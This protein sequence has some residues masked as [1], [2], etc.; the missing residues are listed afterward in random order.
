MRTPPFERESPEREAHLI[1]LA[2]TVR[3]YMRALGAKEQI[4]A[5]I[6]ISDDPRARLGGF[7]E[8]GPSGGAS[9]LG[10]T[11]RFLPG[12]RDT[13]VN[14]GGRQVIVGDGD[15]RDS[16]SSPDDTSAHGGVSRGALSGLGVPGRPS[17]YGGIPGAFSGEGAGG[18]DDMG[19]GGGLSESPGFL[20]GIG[21]GRLGSDPLL[22]ARAWGRLHP[23][24]AVSDDPT[25]TVPSPRGADGSAENIGANAGI[26][27]GA[28]IA[29][30]TVG[31]GLGLAAATGKPDAE[32]VAMH[33]GEA[34]GAAVGRALG[35]VGSFISRHL[36]A[37]DATGT[38]PG[39]PRMNQQRPGADL[40]P[41]DDAS[42]LRGPGGPRL[43]QRGR[44]DLTP[45][46]DGVGP[47]GPS[48][49]LARDQRR[50]L[51][52]PDVMPTP[53]DAGGG[54]PWSNVLRPNDED[55]RPGNPILQSAHVA[56]SDLLVAAHT[57]FT[58]GRRV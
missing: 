39:G 8:F 29:A 33:V 25:K 55:P 30:T 28:A 4:G 15:G 22:N 38:G 7:G 18:G 34:A 36:P 6:G 10:D 2:E 21:R 54:T 53:D 1:S 56:V 12:G 17:H 3:R 49:R 16:G 9:W 43:Q 31:L 40:L 14:V 27:F 44:G 13:G 5:G 23:G 37:D 20:H 41:A 11:S 46:D 24:D 51:F 50:A 45:T 52:T 26:G 42:G 19:G 47:V 48:L 58:G 32:F 35:A 57:L